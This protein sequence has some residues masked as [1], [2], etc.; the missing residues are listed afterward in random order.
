MNLKDKY[1]QEVDAIEKHIKNIQDILTSAELE[2]LNSEDSWWVDYAAKTIVNDF[3]EDDGRVPIWIEQY[4]TQGFADCHTFNLDIHL[5]Y[6]ILP[7]LK[8][9]KELA[10]GCHNIHFPLD[11]MIEAFELLM[12]GKESYKEGEYE[13]CQKKIAEGLENFGK[14]FR[15]LWW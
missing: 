15:S 4:K 8:R 13:E 11:S 6:L 14:H 2:S 10:S 7:R 5:M 12:Y 3:P 1:F 9:Y